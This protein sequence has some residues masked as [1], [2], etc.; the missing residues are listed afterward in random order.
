MVHVVRFGG[1]TQPGLMECKDAAK[2]LMSL[3]FVFRPIEETLGDA[4]K[5]FTDGGFLD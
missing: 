3:G 2:R 4:V 1:D 5:S